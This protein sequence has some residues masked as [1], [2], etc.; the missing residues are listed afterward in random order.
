MK[1]RRLWLWP[2]LAL[3]LAYFLQGTGSSCLERHKGGVAFWGFSS[4]ERRGETAPCFLRLSPGRPSASLSAEEHRS[5]D[6][7][8]SPLK[9][10]FLAAR[11][12][13]GERFRVRGVAST[14]QSQAEDSCL[15]KRLK[16]ASSDFERLQLL[17][18]FAQQATAVD[19]VVSE[20]L[21]ADAPQP[22]P[23]KHIRA[24][25]WGVL[26]QDKAF[27]R[28]P[29]KCVAG[30]TAHVYVQLALLRTP[31]SGAS[32]ERS[33]LQLREA[34][35]P[36][37]SAFRLSGLSDSLLVGGLLALLASHIERRALSLEDSRVELA[38][39]ELLTEWGLRSLLPSERVRGFR[40]VAEAVEAQRRLLE[41]VAE[42]PSENTQHQ[43]RGSRPRASMPRASPVG[44][45]AREEAKI[46]TEVHRSLDWTGQVSA[47]LRAV[48]S[49]AL[50]ALRREACERRG[51]SLAVEEN[52]LSGG[53][54]LLPRALPWTGGVGEEVSVLLSGGVD[55][56]T[57]LQLLQKAGLRVRAFFLKVWSPEAEALLAEEGAPSC[58]WKK[59]AEAARA[60]AA[61][62][63]VALEEIPMQKEYRKRVLE[64]MLEEAK[65]VLAWGGQTFA[66]NGSAPRG[67]PP[68]EVCLSCWPQTRPHAQPR[69]VVQLARQVRGLS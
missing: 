12:R 38:S 25:Q 11:L 67:T 3:F 69:L 52:A 5:E 21:F 4:T 54:N 17:S 14:P 15:A 29:W 23:S 36:R 2:L 8:A 43:G 26:F 24:C 46:S 45:S 58:P 37:P 32:S 60:A 28:T 1:R 6:I 35:Q 49:E 65:Y 59:D 33:A 20:E 63:G 57:S 53:R 42:K 10:R 68:R 39:E 30:C 19:A 40:K 31:L 44:D 56:S 62:A 51:E 50:E 7:A 48:V 55:S 9:P 13:K 16:E 18:R 41:E 34:P 64:A 66:R 22:H 47:Q 61:H 27:A